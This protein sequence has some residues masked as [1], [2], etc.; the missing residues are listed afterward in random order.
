MR[1][2]DSDQQ[3]VGWFLLWG[4]ENRRLDLTA[5][6]ATAVLL[7]LS[8]ACLMASGPWEWDETIFARGM[9][10]FELAAHFPQPPGFPGLLA[11][12]HLLWPLAGSP[13]QALQWVS[14][15]ASVLALW[16]L[17]ILGRKVAPPAVATAAALLVLFLPGPWLYSVRGFSTW[18]AVTMTLTAAAVLV[19]GLHNRRV[20]WFTLLVTSAFL[21]RPILLP[22]LAL[23]WLVGVN[24]VRPVRRILP[25]LLAGVLL[26]VLSVVVMAHLEGGWAAFIE[27]FVAHADYHTARL[28]LNR[29]GIAD[30]G[31]ANG[32]GGAGI[33]VVLLISAAVGL[34]VWR[35]RVSARAAIAWLVILGLTSVQLY[36]LQN[37]SYARYSVGVQVALAPLLAGAASLAPLPAALAG[38]LGL[39]G[40][41]AWRSLPLLNEQHDE[42]FG[43]WEATMDAASIAAE[44]DWAVVVEPEVHVFSSY[45]W[46]LLESDGGSAP[47]MVLSPRAP[48]PWLG[49]RRPWLV[50][51][52]HPHLY[53]PSLTGESRPYGRVSEGLEPLTQNRFLSAELIANPPLPVGQWWT[54]EHLPDGTPFMWAGPSAELWLPPAPAGT[55]VG[56]ALRP[57][58]GDVPLQVSI[59]AGS[60]AAELDGGGETAWI[61]HRLDVDS[62]SEPV[63]VNLS[64][65]SGYPPGDGDER[66]LSAQVLG[67]VVRPPGSG[68]GGRVATEHDR[69]R[70]R[71]EVEGGY[72]PEIFGELGRGVWLEPEARLRIAIDEPGRLVLRLASP[73]PTPANPRI[74]IEGRDI[75][76]QGDTTPQFSVPVDVSS[77]DIADGMVEIQIAS[78]VF[79]PADTGASADIRRLGVVLLGLDF[80]PA[81]PTTGW[82]TSP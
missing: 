8:R 78:D 36:A 64:R 28:H 80:E 51:T 27:P 79:I 21:I 58:L 75:F 35:R 55:L 18:A 49:V 72:G 12:G 73:R 40:M 50:A 15:I 10:H 13:Y 81:N 66:P 20:T 54:R 19:G 7:V 47:P 31:M 4:L 67:V 30:L 71:L 53:L 77:D 3:R 76:I 11:L 82:W 70:L 32:V 23:L 44:H 48:E 45:W 26:I 14:A 17:S 56:L 43:P 42:F 34:L 37:R 68:F 65:S 24:T 61:W 22:T 25:G 5:T 52:V 62:L 16:P 2:G 9:L 33:A 46:H 29:P 59:D 60:F 74:R 6:L 39:A 57:A 38:T 1:S 63:I 41:A 69:W